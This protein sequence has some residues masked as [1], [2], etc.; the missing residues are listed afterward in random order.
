MFLTSQ[1]FLFGQD[2]VGGRI[3]SWRVWLLIWLVPGLFGLA[4]VMLAGETA[5]R[6]QQTVPGQGAVVRVYDWPGETIFDR[7]QTN[8]GPVFRYEFKPGEMTEASVGMSH[9]D[10]NFP[11]GEV[12]DIR[13]DPRRKTNVIL[14]GP[15]NWAVAMVI[16][17]IALVTAVPAIWAHRRA[18]RW[19]K[20]AKVR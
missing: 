2:E 6:I 7:G 13:F 12:H 19:Q 3:V 8:Y 1:P 20:A 17:V 16:G 5:W 11:I 14:S 9:P 10:W 15:H 4:A 18:R